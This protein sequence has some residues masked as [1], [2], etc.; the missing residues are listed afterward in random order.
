MSSDRSHENWKAR[1]AS[2]SLP[3]QAY[4]GGRFVDAA[5]GASFESRNPANGQLNT[6]VVACSVEDVNRAVLAARQAFAAKTWAGRKPQYRRA[7]LLKLA[8]AMEAA[9]DELALLETLD[10]GKPIRFAQDDVKGAIATFRYYAEAVDKVYGEI[11]PTGDQD[12]SLILREPLGVVAAI[13]PWNFPLLMAAWKVAPALA[14]GNTVILKP[15]E[16][17]PLS[18]L[19]LAELVAQVGIPDGIFNVLPGFGETVGKPLALHMDVNALAFTGSTEVGKL[20]LQYAGQS[21]MKRISLECGGKSP[22]ILMADCPDL[23]A[24][25]NSAAT[26]I[27][28][29]QGEVC[30]AGSRLFVQESLREAALEKL[31]AA[32]RYWQPGDPLL[33]DTTFGS[34]V[35]ET[36]MQRVLGY[37]EQGQ[38]EQASL[39]TGGRRVLEETGGFYVEPTVFDRVSQQA[40]LAREEIFGPVLSVI[41]FEDINEALHLANDSIYGL[42]AGVWT[43]DLSTAMRMARGLEAGLIWVNGWDA[44][45]ITVPFGG[46]KQSGIGRDRSL[47]ALEKYSEMKSVWMRL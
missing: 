28:Y 18:A 40:T 1:A 4:I 10:V 16:Q 42:A 31:Q 44:D 5:E 47:H 21:N 33:P 46:Y 38:R 7:M 2:L 27:F 37:I 29:N 23:D 9:K 3:Q 6:K 14:M 35:D 39:L 24:A 26:A 41:G 15:A 17:S 8:D 45:N 25:I 20:I 13:V 36:Q 30:T 32:T 43:S 12:L 19:K 22:H 11:G 34:L